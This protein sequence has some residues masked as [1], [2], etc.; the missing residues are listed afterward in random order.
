[1]PQVMKNN[2]I[3]LIEGSVESYNLALVGSSL[4]T[5]RKTKN[6]E[7]KFAP[8]IGLLGA[9]VELLI[10]ACLVQAK[11][12][13]AIYKDG[14]VETGVYRFGTEVLKDFKSEVASDS[15][16]VTFLWKNQTDHDEQRKSLLAYLNKFTIL[17]SL[18]AAGLHAGHGCSRDIVISIANDIY[19]FY[20]LLAEGKKFRPYLKSIP[21][22]ESTVKDRVAIIE[23]LSRRVTSE[24]NDSNKLGLLKGMYLVLPYVPDREPEWIERMERAT[25]IPPSKDDIKYLV[26]TLEDAHS[27]FLLKNRGGKEGIPVKIEPNNPE[28]LPIAIHNIKRKLNGIPA[29]FNN[30]VISANTRIDQNRLDLP[31]DDFLIDLFALGIEQS[32]ILQEQTNLTAQQVWPF[33]VSAFS[34][35]G[36]PRPCMELIT[37]CDEKDQ[38]L[39]F[40]EKAFKI[41]NGYYKRR[42]STVVKCINAIKNNST[43]TLGLEKDNAFNDITKYSAI[44]G[45]EKH[46]NEISSFVRNNEISKDT[47]NILVDYFDRRINPGKVIEMILSE[48]DLDDNDVRIVK[49][50]ISRCNDYDNRNG[51][52][53]IIRHDKLKTIHS[54]TRKRMFALDINTYIHVRQAGCNDI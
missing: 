47:A 39:A 44:S 25:M 28:A 23:D 4:P 32:G 27:I 42:H 8:V 45:E 20:K 53:A 11:G 36:T 12:D 52:V 43:L 9:S 30:D 1:M 19:Q 29:E 49:M 46:R 16:N 48:N 50:L 14:N 15:P 2:A 38:L 51:L 3:A 10:K 37:R 18:R 6:S 7:A 33:V 41:G 26:N 22:P 24:K 13:G 21:V 5:I 31:I 54:V 34:T 17:Q 35:Q 40:L